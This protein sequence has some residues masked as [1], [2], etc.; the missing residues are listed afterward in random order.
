MASFQAELYGYLDM[1]MLPLGSR[2]YYL[3]CLHGE[4]IIEIISLLVIQDLIQL[5]TFSLLKSFKGFLPFNKKI[6]VGPINNCLRGKKN[7][8]QRKYPM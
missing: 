8:K 7:S 5:Y 4:H 6:F 1:K 2:F 3:T